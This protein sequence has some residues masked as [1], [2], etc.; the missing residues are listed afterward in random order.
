[1]K[2]EIRVLDACQRLWKDR[3]IRDF[4]MDELAAEAGLSKRTVYKYYRSKEEIITAVVDRMIADMTAESERLLNEGQG[5]E[6]IFHQVLDYLFVRASFLTS[7]RSLEDM[8][9]YYPHIW[10][11]VSAFRIQRLD[12]MV[13]A[14][15]G[16]ASSSPPPGIDM[17][18]AKAIVIASIT[19][20]LD[21]RFL[22]ENGISFQ[23]ATCQVF[24]L[25]L[26]MLGYDQS[27]SLPKTRTQDSH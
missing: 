24:K 13:T 21:P 12:Y 26:V 8:M 20:I 7:R 9:R 15:T 25:L 17:R 23:E 3:G 5:P 16:R 18:I 11:K 2:S 10:Q 27:I 22:L 6:A 1:M 4:T 14:V 19:N